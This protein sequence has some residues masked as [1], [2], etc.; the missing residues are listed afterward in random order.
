MFNPFWYL[1]LVAIGAGLTAWLGRPWA[2]DDL[3]YDAL[4]AV[5]RTCLLLWLLIFLLPARF[6]EGVKPPDGRWLH[7]RAVA[8]CMCGREQDDVWRAVPLHVIDSGCGEHVCCRGSCT[9]NKDE[10]SE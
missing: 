6:V 10:K 5:G 8:C 2:V 7:W 4:S 9:S 3:R 1:L